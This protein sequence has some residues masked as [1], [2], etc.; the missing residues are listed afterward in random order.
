MRP[1]ISKKPEMNIVGMSFYGDPFNTYGGWDGENEIGRVWSRF[2]KFMEANATK[3]ENITKSGV[4][5]EVHIYDEETIAKGVFEVF[6]GVRVNKIK[7]IPV[8]LLVKTLPASEYAV[9]TFKGTAISSDWYLSIDQ[10]VATA[11][12]RRVP[13][14]MFQYYDER[15]KGVDNIAASVL[16][17][18]VSVEPVTPEVGR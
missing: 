12:Y 16:D 14:F 2:M 3:I 13:S 8:E 1:F 5:Y 15:F 18:Y 17:V 7:D 11:G 10:W 6:V 4:F 9:F